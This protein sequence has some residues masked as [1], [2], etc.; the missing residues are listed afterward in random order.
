LFF[1]ILPEKRGSILTMVDDKS[2]CSSLDSPACQNINTFLS[3]NEQNG[4]GNLTYKI[5]PSIYSG[6]IWRRCRSI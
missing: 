4:H 1:A 5:K 3:Y 6:D 2:S